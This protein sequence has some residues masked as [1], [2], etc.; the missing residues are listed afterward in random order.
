MS[1]VDA[2]HDRANAGVSAT[3]FLLQDLVDSCRVQRRATI[4]LCQFG[5]NATAAPPLLLLHLLSKK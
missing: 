3:C 1:E 5:T 4:L 2:G